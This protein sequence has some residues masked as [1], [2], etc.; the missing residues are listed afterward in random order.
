MKL[1]YMIFILLSIIL[2]PVFIFEMIEKISF[3]S[4]G[5]FFIATTGIWLGYF[6]IREKSGK[7]ARK[8]IEDYLIDKV[9]KDSK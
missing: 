4:V 2:I 9:K 3:E 6:A 8:K 7:N 5:L 1:V